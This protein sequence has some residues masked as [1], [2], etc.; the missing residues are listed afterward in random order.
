MSGGFDFQMPC[1]G[2]PGDGSGGGQPPDDRLHRQI[3]ELEERLNRIMLAN[4]QLRNERDAANL[5][6]TQTE[7]LLGD[8]TAPTVFNQIQVK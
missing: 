4:R 7:Q 2:N 5:R 1:G 6:L 8:T 3:Q